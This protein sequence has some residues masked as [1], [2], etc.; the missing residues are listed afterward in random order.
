MK[1]N[2]LLVKKVGRTTGN[3]LYKIFRYIL[4]I[5]CS[6]MVLYPVIQMVSAALT[7]PIELLQGNGGILPNNP[8]FINFKNMMQFFP[9]WKH[10]I[11]TV[12]I[13]GICTILQLI[14]CSLVG[15]GLGRYKFKGNTLVFV[16]AIFT[17]LM[18]LQVALIP[19]YYNYRF[20]DFFGIG[21]L[22]GLIT[23]K[24]L[25][26]NLLPNFVGMYL[27]AAFG[28][29][30]NSG[31]FIFLFKQYFESMPKDLEEAAKLDGCGPFKTFLRVMVPNI[32][33]V[34]VTVA[35]LSVIYYWNDTMVS[36][37]MVGSD[38]KF[39][40]MSAIDQIRN[41]DFASSQIGYARLIAERY[42]ML[43]TVVAPLM[44]I[45]AVCQKFFVESMDRSGS[46]G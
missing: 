7:D 19:M 11:P 10:L 20:F 26:V 39:T 6:Y 1:I 5:G 9:Y 24:D 31:I 36:D 37:M 42:A 3:L 18:P 12:Q 43:T 34:F 17:F 35:L 38:G 33:P 8:T 32:K 22:V 41:K 40:L 45:F 16:A 30:L 46:K 27:P 14:S 29:G 23:G 4:L 2:P 21:K 13:A 25:T 28:V 15:Y 44:I